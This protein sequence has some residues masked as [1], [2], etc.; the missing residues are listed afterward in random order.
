VSKKA[1]FTFVLDYKGGTYLSQVL[2]S[3]LADA[4]QKWVSTRTSEEL[5]TWS[6]EP[7]DLAALAD[8][9]RPVAIQGCH[10]VW[11]MSGST[12]EH[13]ILITIIATKLE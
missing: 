13:L 5:N 2:A 6:L 9:D 4:A 1:L 7:Q 10:N 12:E 11:C 8:A 3:S